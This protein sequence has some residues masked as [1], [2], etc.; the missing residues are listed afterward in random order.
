LPLRWS[1]IVTESEPGGTLVHYSQGLVM[2]IQIGLAVAFVVVFVLGIRRR[3]VTFGGTLLAALAMVGTGVVAGAAVWVAYKLVEATVR[4]PLSLLTGGTYNVTLYDVGFAGMAVAVMALLY[5]WYRK[6][7]TGT[8]LLMGAALVTLLLGTAFS[9]MLPGGSYLLQWPLLVALL[10]LA[11]RFLAADSEA[12][13]VKVVTLVPTALA[14]ILLVVPAVCLMMP[15]SMHVALFGLMV[16]LLGL[17][18]PHLEA[19]ASAGRWLVP[20]EGAAGAVVFLLT[21]VILSAPN[22]SHP[23]PSSVWYSLN[24]DAGEAT[25][26]SMEAE[27]DEYA[28]QFLTG[29]VTLAPLSGFAPL[30]LPGVGATAK[31][32]VVALPAPA[33]TLLGSRVDEGNRTLHL[34][35][36]PG[37]GA[38][39]IVVKVA[40]GEVL[41]AAV[42]GRPVAEP[43][44]LAQFG[45]FYTTPGEGFDLSLTV[46][47]TGPVAVQ[48][49]AQ[50]DGFAVVGGQVQ[51]R[52][53]H[54]MPGVE[55]DGKSLVWKSFEF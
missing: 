5:T 42:G 16:A 15:I 10:A 30:P 33:V 21:A 52:P 9:L 45:L 47:G 8:N 22:A 7:I 1:Y 14:S 39:S 49:T 24:A 40:G 17:V 23:A 55:L 3:A 38:E 36:A 50:F 37:A 34:R 54:L 46:K 31:A 4:G 27:P 11:C 12:T 51:P 29:P 26:V 6:K 41:A 43:G 32:P 28:R 13:W 25:W 2:P 53:A 18:A 48:A 20:G 35:L 19:M 44:A